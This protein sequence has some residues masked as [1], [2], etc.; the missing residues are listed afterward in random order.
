[1]TSV[2]AIDLTR[3]S[4]VTDAEA[5]RLASPAAFADV[6]SQITALPP[7]AD[8]AT[9][10]PGQARPGQAGP[11]HTHPGHPRP[12]ALRRARRWSRRRALLA[13]L[14][15]AVLAGAAALFVTLLA[16][17]GG[18]SDNGAS[19]QAGIQ[20]LSFTRADGFITVIIRNPYADVSAYNAE[21]ARQH[22][23]ISLSLT[24]VSPSFVGNIIGAD[25]AQ[26]TYIPQPGD[27]T[28]RN[29]ES[30]P[31][32]TCTIGF[33][34][35]ASFHGHARVQVGRP[36][37]PGEVYQ[38]S[39]SALSPGEILYPL[40]DQ[41]FDH[42]LSQV[43][44]VLAKNHIT[45]ADCRQSLMFVCRGANGRL[46]NTPTSPGESYVQDAI[47]VA[48]GQVIIVVG[49]KTLPPKD[50]AFAPDPKPSPTGPAPS[51]TPTPAKSS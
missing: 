36:A 37:R 28:P 4:P 24:P 32:A 30:L 25:G 46:M 14:P 16:P 5:A 45:I 31:L 47:P 17:N 44:P 20:A 11:G 26:V 50:E 33:R 35:P 19:S 23:D 42:P 15:L 39:A 51:V 22:I 29:P 8:P 7:L 3:I 1:M 43:L 18:N 9:E 40:R 21:F 12:A 2:P 38:I 6:A 10:H 13:G 49:V 27:C 41:V 34:V 48:S